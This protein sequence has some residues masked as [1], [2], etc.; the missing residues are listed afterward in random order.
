MARVAAAG[1]TSAVP[2]TVRGPSLYATA[3]V[4]PNVREIGVFN[5]TATAVAV[6][7]CRASATGTQGAGLTEVCQD[8]DSH[9]IIATAFNTHTADATVGSPVRQ[10]SLGA[11]IGSGVIFTFGGD[12]LVIDNATT[13][14]LVITCPTGTAQHLDFYIEW[15]E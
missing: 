3:G 1:R 2:T 10:A 12:G 14:G 15:T 8:D 13:A 9:T 5:T 4:R 6:A 11:A 7:I